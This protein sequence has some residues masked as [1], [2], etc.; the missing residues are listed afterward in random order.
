MVLLKLGSDEIYL[1]HVDGE[2]AGWLRYGLFWDKHPFMNMLFVLEPYRNQGFGKRL[3]SKW[4]ED[5]VALG[6][7]IVM[8][9]TM[10]N[11]EAQHFYRK[12]G[13]RDIGGLIMPNEPQELIFLKE[14]AS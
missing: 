1:L 7:N 14:L 11:E 2:F 8:T 9:S 10:S 4:E 5:M 12:M 13:Y 6:H 3:V